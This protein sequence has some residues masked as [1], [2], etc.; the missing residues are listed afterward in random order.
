MNK[1]IDN[2]HNMHYN[3]KNMKG[4]NIMAQTNLTIRIDEDIKRE[5]ELLFGKI[6]LNMSSAINVFFRQAVRE[7]AI[8]FEL[9]PYDDYYSGQR[10]QRILNSK[11]QAERGEVITKTLAELEAMENE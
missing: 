10:L 3:H 7:Q 11:A 5:A 6:G 8:P 1:Y 4:G 2:A 9:K